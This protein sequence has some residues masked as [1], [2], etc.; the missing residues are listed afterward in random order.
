LGGHELGH[1]VW[2]RFGLRGDVKETI[3][4]SVQ[5]HMTDNWSRLCDS[6]QIGFAKATPPAENTVAIPYLKQATEWAV[7]QVQETFCDYLGVRLFGLPFLYA[8]AYVFSPRPPHR[9][10]P[11]YPELRVRVSNAVTYAG[12]HLDVPED[13]AAVFGPEDP[14][15]GTGNRLLYEIADRAR[16][17]LDDWAIARVEAI[18]EQSQV[19]LPDGSEALRESQ[20]IRRCF[21]LNV[22]AEQ[23]RGLADILSAAWAEFLTYREFHRSTWR[24]SD[25]G[26]A[27]LPDEEARKRRAG[28][29]AQLKD[30]VLK[31]IEIYEIEHLMAERP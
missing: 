23:A 9:R 11:E 24:E 31:T 22:P 10:S 3:A 5:Q 29:A 30:V 25:S 6:L 28:R 16:A 12:R 4:L 21:E 26:Q 18:V 19:D 2:R 20:R 8:M 13:L 1:A 17:D 27:D 7:K 14:P 15:E